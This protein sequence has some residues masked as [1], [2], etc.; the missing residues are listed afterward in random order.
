MVDCQDDQEVELKVV[1]DESEEDRIPL[2]KRRCVVKAAEKKDGSSSST[3]LSTPI[4]Q[5]FADVIAALK[6]GVV[7]ELKHKASKTKAT[8]ATAEF[9]VEVSTAP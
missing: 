4:K 5:F 3:L 9:V 8:S 6:R 1:E 2:I 7:E